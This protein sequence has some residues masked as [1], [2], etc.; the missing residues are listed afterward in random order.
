MK[1]NPMTCKCGIVLFDVEVWVDIYGIHA[2]CPGCGVTYTLASPRFQSVMTNISEDT[3]IAV[4]END[5][6]RSSP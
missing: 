2:I 4:L 1:D 3:P 5:A 6:V